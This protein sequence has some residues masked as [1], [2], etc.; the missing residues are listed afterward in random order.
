MPPFD[1]AKVT[2]WKDFLELLLVLV[3]IPWVLYKLLTDPLDLMRKRA[4]GT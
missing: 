3:A 2:A 1:P 4:E